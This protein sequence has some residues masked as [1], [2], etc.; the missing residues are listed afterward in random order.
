M[1]QAKIAPLSLYKQL[2]GKDNIKISTA[3][4]RT[5]KMP[6]SLMQQ[7]KDISWQN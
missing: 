3:R 7:N 4:W 1:S 5:V 6:L 2:K